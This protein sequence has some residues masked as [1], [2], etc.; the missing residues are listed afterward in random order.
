MRRRDFL[1]LLASGVV[2]SHIDV[3]R[4]LWEPNKKTIFLPT[5]AQIALYNNYKYA[6]LYGIPYHQSNA[7]TGQWLGIPRGDS[8]YKELAEMVRLLEKLKHDDL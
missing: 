4:L 6:A 7:S 1:R 2:G 8:V 5:D 3:D